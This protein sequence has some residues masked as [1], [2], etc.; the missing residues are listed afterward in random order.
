LR[1]GAENFLR[2]R[3]LP[4]LL[5]GLLLAVTGDVGAQEWQLHT[6][7]RGD[8]LFSIA[9]RYEVTVDELREWNRLRDNR[10][11]VGQRLRIPAPDQETYVVRPGDSLS[12]IAARHDITVDLLRRLNGLRDSRIQPGQKLKL[13]PA[14]ADSPVHV[15]REGESLS[16]IAQ[17]GGLSLAELRRINGLE[18]DR[19][20]VGQK[21]RLREAARTVHIVES[22]D[23][24]WEIARA[25]GIP[26][27][28]LKRM[29]GLTSDRIYPGQ[30][31]QLSAAAA[32]RRVTYKVR[33]G[34]NLTEIAR[35]HQMS[36]NE[37]RELNGL[38][39]S[40]IHPGQVL[41]VRPSP[42]LD[43][44]S[45][46][47]GP[48]GVDWSALQRLPGLRA[49]SATNGPYYESRPRAG[50]QRSREYAEG[51]VHSVAA[52]YRQAR[53]VWQAFAATVAAQP[54]LSNRLAGWHFVLDPGHGGVDPGTI[55]RS[56]DPD[57]KAFYIVEDEYVYDVALRVY[58]LLRLHGADVTMT[59][60]SPNHALRGNS[61]VNDTFVH[62]RN[63]VI[64][65]AAFCRRNRDRPRGGQR[66]LDARIAVAREAFRG[67]PRDRQVFLSFHADNVAAL[68]DVVT[69]FYL[70]N[71]N[72]TDTVSRDFGRSLLTSLGAG[73]RVKGKNLGVLRNNPARYK[74]L[75][76]MR[77]LAFADHIWAIRYEELRQRDAVKI[78]QA[79]LDRLD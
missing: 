9:R 25:Y 32:A 37:L 49:L 51:Q 77:N 38:R 63:E 46:G 31:L 8:T 14:P 74:L 26:V 27:D 36:L 4:V 50:A 3:C 34:D 53:R 68:G 5:A 76:E 17:R 48:G 21:L 65:G 11:L 22:G 39:G 18:G 23:A 7:E 16:V 75:V 30:E 28:E 41:Q 57:G 40:V 35:L 67:V 6:V 12:E 15:V 59:L 62:E 58:A 70:Q 61:P 60:L 13:R 52:D 64:N 79:L 10:I 29:N 45:D 56:V 20:Y 71:G 42:G 1:Q 72:G 69:L 43:F 78:V 66:H 54:R 33:P 44:R 19:I 2:G 55:K 73:A 47:R 24:L